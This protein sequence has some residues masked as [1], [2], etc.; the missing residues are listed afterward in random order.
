MELTAV[1]TNINYDLYDMRHITKTNGVEADKNKH[2][3]NLSMTELKA[4][5]TWKILAGIILNKDK[6]NV[7]FYAKIV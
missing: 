1:P 5:H 4:K 6:S 7:C 2:K 3:A